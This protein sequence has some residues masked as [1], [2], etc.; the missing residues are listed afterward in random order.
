MKAPGI[1]GGCLLFISAWQTYHAFF[2]AQIRVRTQ[3]ILHMELEYILSTI[4]KNEHPSIAIL[5]ATYN[6]EQ[7]LAEQLNSILNQERVSVHIFI[8]DDLST[9]RTW[10]I[11][12]SYNDERISLLPRDR[13]F[14]S[15]AQNFFRLL[16]DVDLSD[17]DYVSLSDQDDIWN[18]DKLSHSVSTLIKQ[19][20]DAISS[21][22]IAFWPDGD[23]KTICKSQPQQAWDH[24]FQSAGPG[25]TYVLCRQLA[26]EISEFLQSQQAKTIGI[27]LHDWFL[28]AWSRSNGYRWW[29]DPQP[30]MLYR[31]HCANEFGANH[32]LR[33]VSDRWHK[34]RDGWYRT[35]VLTIASLCGATETWPVK[36]MKRYRLIDRIVLILHI[37]QI[38]RRKHECFALAIAFL[39]PL[40][41]MK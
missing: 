10:T 4:I 30:T 25:C 11:L 34:L 6:G 14:G 1:A 41:V 35:Q 3:V 29:I 23:K 28:Y 12:Q 21:N 20:V 2:F 19:D 32:G 8:S 16:R 7:W 5:L 24:F 27:A 33:A 39:M 36:R 26:V 18:L 38:R 9:D 15:A 13:R 31:Q 40:R 22:V 37:N 17:F